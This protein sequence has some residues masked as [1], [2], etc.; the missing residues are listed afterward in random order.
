MKLNDILK[1][2]TKKETIAEFCRRYQVDQRELKKFFEKMKWHSGI[3]SWMKGIFYWVFGLSMI[4]NS[5][6]ALS[7]H[8]FWFPIAQTKSMLSFINIFWVISWFV[9]SIVIIVWG[10]IVVWRYYQAEEY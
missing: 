10:I 7:D 1:P 9:A 8:Y 6:M 5:I 3:V 4:V 2:K